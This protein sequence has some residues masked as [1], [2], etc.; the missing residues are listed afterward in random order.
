MLLLYFAVQNPS[1]Q[2]DSHEFAPNLLIKISTNL[3][4]LYR[5]S[6]AVMNGD[7]SDIFEC[8]REEIRTCERVYMIIDALDV[9][10]SD[11]RDVLKRESGRLQG[12]APHQISL[13]FTVRESVEHKFL[14]NC[15]ACGRPDLLVYCSCA[16]CEGP[17]SESYDLCHG[18]K[19]EGR[20]CVE[21][22]LIEEKYK[23]IEMEIRPEED[24]LRRYIDRRIRNELDRTGPEGFDQRKTPNR[25]TASRFV[26]ICREDD[27]MP[28]YITSALIEKAK[29]NLLVTKCIWM[30]L[31]R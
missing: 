1:P 23:V 17:N 2:Y 15:N 7:W 18:C 11:V 12:D 10:P 6:S 8:L 5:Q 20:K 26:Q 30:S 25:S 29:R 13:M 22:H 4:S 3:Q 21:S 28:Q 19:E 16:I 14:I 31:S 27:T 9:C 24:D